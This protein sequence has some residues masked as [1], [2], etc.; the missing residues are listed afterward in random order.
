MSQVVIYTQN[1]AVEVLIPTK[2][3]LE[4]YGIEAIALKDVPEGA[5]FKIVDHADIPWD[6]AQAAW[7]VNVAELTDGVGATG[8]S[9]PASAVSTVSANPRRGGRP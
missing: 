8:S 9:F 4:E 1:G 2:E 6:V 5:P 7:Q 3:A